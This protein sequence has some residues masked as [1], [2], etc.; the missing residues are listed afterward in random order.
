MKKII[1]TGEK[2]GTGKSTISAL[3]VEYLNH[4]EHKVQ[5]NYLTPILSNRLRKLTAGQEDFIFND[6]EQ[7]NQVSY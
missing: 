5:R 6:K 7:A 4:L 3:L 2:G 1:V